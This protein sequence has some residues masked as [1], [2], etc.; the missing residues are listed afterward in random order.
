MRSD[1]QYRRQARALQQQALGLVCRHLKPPD[2]SARCSAWTLLSCMLLAAVSRRSLAAVAAL[3]ESWPSRETLRKALFATLP[4]YQGLLASTPRLLQASLPRS[5]RL[6]PGHRQRRRYPMAIDLHGVPYFKR[7][8]APPAHVRKGQPTPGTRYSHQYA[9]CSLLRKGHYYVVALTPYGPGESLADITRRLLQQAAG[10]G[11]RPRYVLLDRGFWATDVLLYLKRARCGFLL[12]VMPRG[13]TAQAKGGPTG[14]QA[15]F[16]KPS[17]RYRYR[18]QNEKRQGV[19][20][21]LL[22]YRSRRAKAKAKDK[23]KTKGSRAWVYGMWGCQ[24]RQAIAVFRRYRRR[25]RIES[26]YRLLEAARGRTSSREEGWRLWYVVLAVL[27]LNLWLGMRRSQGGA[28]AGQELG[29]WVRLL[30]SLTY[31]LLKEEFDGQGTGEGGSDTRSQ[32]VR[33][34]GASAAA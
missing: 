1:C 7:G 30:L 11:L 34:D 10:L 3:N 17:G 24:P 19:W 27:L 32:A 9:T 13:K 5:L 28:R 4:G 8:K 25:F 22:V 33:T 18:M 12:P 21:D 23:A 26:S 29:W 20:V 16:Y 2:F 6:R 15:Y 14:T 31:R